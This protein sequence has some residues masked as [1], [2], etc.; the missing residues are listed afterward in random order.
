MVL[1]G[2]RRVPR[3][4]GDGTLERAAQRYREN[5]DALAVLSILLRLCRN[6]NSARVSHFAS[7]VVLRYS[8]A[9]SPFIGTALTRQSPHV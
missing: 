8:G 6:V 5:F 1:V 3:L 7:S 4:R 9:L 2:R